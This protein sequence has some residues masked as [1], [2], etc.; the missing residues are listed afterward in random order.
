M[1]QYNLLSPFRLAC[2]HM[3]WRLSTGTGC[4]SSCPLLPKTLHP[5]AGPCDLSPIHI[6]L[7]RFFFNLLFIYFLKQSLLNL[8]TNPNS[9]PFLH[10]APEVSFPKL[11]SHCGSA[12]FLLIL[13]TSV[14]KRVLSASNSQPIVLTNFLKTFHGKHISQIYSINR[15]LVCSIHRYTFKINAIMLSCLFNKLND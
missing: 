4:P 12:H 11:P 8:H 5:E 1:C 9:P 10:N 14:C 7:I 6:Y 3:L 13:H 2:M 15:T